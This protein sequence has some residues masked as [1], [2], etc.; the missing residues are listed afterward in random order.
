MTHRISSKRV[1]LVI[2]VLI[3]LGLGIES[4]WGQRAGRWT[5][6]SFRGSATTS[7]S[8]TVRR[9]TTVSSSVNRNTLVRRNTRI[10]VNRNTNINVD[11]DVNV[12]G[13]PGYYG[14]RYDNDAGAFVAGA[15]I[16]GITG[17]AIASASQPTLV[18]GSHVSVLPSGCVTLITAGVTYHRCDTLYYRPYYNGS[19]LVYEIV[20]AP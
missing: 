19:S 15:V 2:G 9:R 5:S 13:R 16:G 4:A 8:G 10:N 20:P 14:D 7:V 6:R 1:A 12:W 3:G 11:R 18:V 17:A